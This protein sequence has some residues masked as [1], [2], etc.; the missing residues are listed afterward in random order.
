MDNYTVYKHTSPSG[1]AY[2]G[3][4][5]KKVRDRW[6]YGHGYIFNQYF[7]NAI[8]KYGWDN[9]EHQVL[10]TGL[11]AEEAYA[12][13]KELIAFYKAKGMC[14]NIAEG[15]IDGNIRPRTD[16]ERQH[17]RE[18][19]LEYFKNNPHPLLGTKMSEEAK[20]EAGKRFKRLWEEDYDKMYDA[21]YKKKVGAFNTLTGSYLEYASEKEAAEDLGIAQTTLRK[22]VDNSRILNGYILYPLDEIPF[23]EALRKAYNNSLVNPRSDYKEVGVVQLSLDGA[24]IAAF[25][26]IKKAAL[27]TG[28]R[29]AGIGEVC[30]NHIKSSGGYMWVF[31]SEY[32]K[33]IEEGT[34]DTFLD[35]KRTNLKQ[36]KEI[37]LKP[38][39][40]VTMEGTVMNIFLSTKGIERALGYDSSG[41]SKCC[42]GKLDHIY[43]YKWKYI[44]KEEYEHYKLQLAAQ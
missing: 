42:R 43:G 15:G 11:T 12:K 16:E 28:N 38:V 10:Y 21:I 41:I 3:I 44:S 14:Y 32:N 2:I 27:I 35:E 26:S 1:K 24:Y 29:E 18:K 19:A 40:Q 34:L 13:E 33:Y 8:K 30:R 4:T 5:R 37:C 6:K 25:P 36:R 17:L 9:I 23:E 7:F 39:L 22:H 20:K 31:S